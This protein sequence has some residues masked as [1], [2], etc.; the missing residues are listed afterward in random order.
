[1]PKVYLTVS[2]QIQLLQNNKGLILSDISFAEKALTE[3]GYFSLISGYKSL[4]RDPSTNSYRT[5][6]TFEDIYTLYEFD[7]ALQ[8]L[9]LRYLKKVERKIRQLISDSF[10][11]LYGEQQSSYLSSSNYNCVPRNQRKIQ[12]LINRLDFHANRNI[13]KEYLIHYRSMGNVPL[14]VTAKALTFGELSTFYSVASFQQQSYI[15]RHYENVS[16]R[17]LERYLSVITLF[18]N[19]C[20][21]N[22]RLYCHKVSQFEFPDTPLHTKLNLP[23]NGNHF[24]SGKNDYCGLLIAL[25]YLLPRKDFLAYKRELSQLIKTCCRK[26]PHIKKDDLLASMGLPANWETI[27]RYRL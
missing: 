18:R 15:S 21:H 19:I 14:W 3:I 1:M 2:Q 5:G 11:S 7:D 6:T 25:R 13:K 23:K 22:E 9:T 10:C 24:L 8:D 4:F 17:K 12:E 20:A 16:E 27:T 26:S